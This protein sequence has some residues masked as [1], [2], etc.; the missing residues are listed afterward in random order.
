MATNSQ[1]E[2]SSIYESLQYSYDKVVFNPGNP[3][4]HSEFP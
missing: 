3:P 1:K 4:L 2:T